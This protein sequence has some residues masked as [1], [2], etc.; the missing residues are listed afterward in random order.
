[1]DETILQTIPHR[2]P[3]LFIDE[4]LEVTETS[5]RCRRYI[6]PAEAHFAGHYPG[7]PIMPGVLLCEA[8]FQTAAVYM[9]R[10][11]ERAGDAKAADKTPVLARIGDARF[12]RMVVP[13]DTIEIETTYKEAVGPF[14]FMKGRVLKDGKP[15][16]TVEFALALVD[17]PAA[18]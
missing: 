10:R 1:M 13:G 6:D 2:P 18:D 14:H 12:K 16:A 5:A 9:V 11:Q 15:A 3:F 8:V 7:N 17:K 4:I